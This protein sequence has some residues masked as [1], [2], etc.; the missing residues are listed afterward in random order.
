ML[1]MALS[2]KTNDRVIEQKTREAI[3]AQNRRFAGQ[4]AAYREQKESFE[5]ANR[6][7]ERRQTA[8]G[9]ARADFDEVIIGRRTVLDTHTGDRSSVDLGDSKQIVDRLNQRDPG[10]YKEIPLR[11][12][13][14]PP[15][16]ERGR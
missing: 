2:L 5:E 6:A 3:N 9:R 15:P 16:P 11:D 7:W 1:A 4:Q 12:E 14:Y 8:Q 13:M 10:R